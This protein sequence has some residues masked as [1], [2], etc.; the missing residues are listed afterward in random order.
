MVLGVLLT[1]GNFPKLRNKD[2]ELVNTLVWC[3]SVLLLNGRGGIW[4]W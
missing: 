3:V 4:V 2:A 1:V